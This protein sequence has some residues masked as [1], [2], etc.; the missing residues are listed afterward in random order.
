MSTH[1]PRRPGDAAAATLDRS[2]ALRRWYNRV[3]FAGY[4]SG[5]AGAVL[6]ALGRRSAERAPRS[7]SFG[8]ALLVLMFL[9]FA[10]SYILALSVSQRRRIGR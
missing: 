5:L 2:A 1:E 8:A 9:L 3:R 4:A 7:L 6:Y 10:A